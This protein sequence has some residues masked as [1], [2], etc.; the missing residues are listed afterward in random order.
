MGGAGAGEAEAL[1]RQI[2]TPEAIV[3]LLNEGRAALA[4]TGALDS[5]SLW[6]MPRLSEAF[7]GGLLEIVRNSTFDGPLSF[8]VGLKSPEGR[9]GV[10]LHLSG[11][12]WRLAGLDVPEAIGARLAREIA[13]R[14]GGSTERRG[15]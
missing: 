15:G 13:V 14:V 7:R 9:Y 2:L 1:L 5:V 10:H 12:T 11:T 8:V 6:R 4:G 3:A